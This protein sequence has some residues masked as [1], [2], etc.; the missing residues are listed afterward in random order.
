MRSED[1]VNETTHLSARRER[2]A[3]WAHFLGPTGL[4]WNLVVT[5]VIPSCNLLTAILN[6]DATRPCHDGI[7]K[8]REG[9]KMKE[10]IAKKVTRTVRTIVS[11]F[12]G[13]GISPNT[14]HV[15]KVRKTEFA[16]FNC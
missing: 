3:P 2:N 8:T 9:T 11:A 4:Y 1:L 16:D 6:R 13:E 12:L 14:D 15:R 10:K 5:R 7:N